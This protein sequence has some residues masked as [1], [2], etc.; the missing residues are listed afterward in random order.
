MWFIDYED[1]ASR[2]IMEHGKFARVASAHSEE[3]LRRAIA[4]HGRP[5]SILN[6]RG[7]TFYAVEGEARKKGLTEFEL[8]LT[9]NHIEHILSLGM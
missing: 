3:V 2:R 9:G 4:E 1:D 8:F 6:D 7:S 5:E